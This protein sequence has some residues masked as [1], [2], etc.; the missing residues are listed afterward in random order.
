MSGG[1]VVVA[2]G[3][4][5]KVKEFTHAFAKLGLQ[6]R[7]LKDYPDVPDIVE[8]GDSFAANARI[9]AGTLGRLLNAPVL[10]DDSGLIVDA[11]GGEPGIY[12]A[13]YSGPGATDAA[14]NAKL[15]QELAAA[16]AEA[17]SGAAERPDGERLLSSARFWCALALYM[18]EQDDFIESEGA[19]EGYIL[20]HPRGEHGF[21]YDPLLW[22]PGKR[23]SAAELSVEEKQQISHRGEALRQLLGKLEQ[24]GVRL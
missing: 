22:I 16:G 7:S 4:A 18:P 19:L 14:N 1:Y 23:R 2:T 17:A 8:D 6:V 11:L 20:E 9:K 15:L 12:S 24:S 5:G 13:R 3:N 21:G 10:A